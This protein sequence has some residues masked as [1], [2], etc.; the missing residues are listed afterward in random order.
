M[1]PRPA[2]QKRNHNLRFWGLLGAVFFVGT[3]PRKR[4]ITCF[5]WPSFLA[6]SM[7]KRAYYGNAVLEQPGSHQPRTSPA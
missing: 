4:I 3:V 5:S 6:P 7:R 1:I 2:T